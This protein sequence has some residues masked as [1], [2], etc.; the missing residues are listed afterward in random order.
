MKFFKLLFLAVLSL[1][2]LTGC[3]RQ[4][5]SPIDP[6]DPPQTTNTQFA[7]KALSDLADTAAE[8]EFTESR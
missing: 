3:E 8:R 6:T 5:L 2:V 7:Q 1:T 4:L